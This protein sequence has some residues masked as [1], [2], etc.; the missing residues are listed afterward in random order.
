MTN[1]L[2]DGGCLVHFHE[3]RR[4]DRWVIP[5]PAGADDARCRRPT[6]DCRR[7]EAA[8]RGKGLPAAR[9][10]SS[11]ARDQP[12][13]ALGC[14]SPPT[15]FGGG[16]SGTRGGQDEAICGGVAD[17]A[18]RHESDGRDR[19]LLRNRSAP[20][21][22]PRLR[23][24]RSPHRSAIHA[25]MRPTSEGALNAAISAS[26]AGCAEGLGPVEKGHR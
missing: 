16:D 19:G 7:G 26:R 5:A 8:V 2:S 15:N 13:S 20:H 11:P 22:T 24:R 4:C 10:R 3:H 21:A 18:A 23:R 12:A 14:R 1:R 17:R 25:M 9:M 6:I